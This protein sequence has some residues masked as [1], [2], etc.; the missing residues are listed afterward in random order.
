MVKGF[1][2]VSLMPGKTKRITFPVRVNDLKYWD[3]NSNGW[4]P[5]SGQVQVMVGPSADNLP[6]MDTFTV[7]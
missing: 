5:P 3:M 6:L 2:R 4:K 1:F 7:Q